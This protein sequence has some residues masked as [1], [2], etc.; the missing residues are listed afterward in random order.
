[1]ALKVSGILAGIF[2][3][4][5][6]P[7]KAKKVDDGGNLLAVV[8]E[9]GKLSEEDFTW[10]QDKCLSVCYEVLP[11]GLTPVLRED[12]NFGVIG[13]EED[14]VTV[15]MLTA[16]ALMHNLSFLK[17][18]SFEGISDKPLDW[19]PVRLQN[20]NEFLFAPVMAGLWTHRD[21]IEDVFTYDDLLDAH[22]I[23]A[24]KYENERRAAEAA[25][26]EAEQRG[27][28]SGRY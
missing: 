22:E 24:V 28:S 7:G 11:A 12:G 10:I 25:R 9:I 18:G 17:E 27:R 2:N 14:T 15:M 1:M 16:H 20:V 6:K 21:L 8:S 13:L 23:L 4:P 26:R 19:V 3:K 5:G